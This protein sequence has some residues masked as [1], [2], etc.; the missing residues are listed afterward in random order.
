MARPEKYTEDDY[1]SWLDDPHVQPDAL[2]DLVN[3][4]KITLRSAGYRLVY[5]VEDDRVVVTV[6]AIG[7]REHGEV[8]SRAHR[9]T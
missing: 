7:K 5:D 6:V 8:Y 1:L 3:C 9:R 2:S 4:Y